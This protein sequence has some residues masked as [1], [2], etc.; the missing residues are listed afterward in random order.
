MR[1]AAVVLALA[2]VAGLLWFLDA[3]SAPV[4]VAVPAPTPTGTSDAPASV[5]PRT[6]ASD[7][8][9]AQR[10]PVPAGAGPERAPDTDALPGLRVRVRNAAGRPVEEVPVKADL[11]AGRVEVRPTGADGIATF[12]I[13]A[14]GDAV[15]AIPIALELPSLEA[16]R[17][18][19][20]A[21]SV[22]RGEVFDLTLPPCGVIAVRLLGGDGQPVGGTPIHLELRPLGPAETLADAPRRNGVGVTAQGGAAEFAF[23]PLH[24]AFALIPRANGLHASFA[25]ARVLGPTVDGQRVETTLREDATAACVVVRLVDAVRA[26]LRDAPITIDLSETIQVGESAG[27]SSTGTTDTTDADGELRLWFAA[28]GPDG[29]VRRVTFAQRTRP[30]AIGTLKLEH[31]LPAGITHV[32]DV[33]LEVERTV[34]LAGVVVDEAD[35]PVA[36]ARIDVSRINRFAGGGQARTGVALDARSDDAGAFAIHLAAAADAE[37]AVSARKDG[38]L[39]DGGVETSYGA[40]GLRLRLRHAGSITGSLAVEPADRELIGIRAGDADSR[41]PRD[42]RLDGETGAFAVASLAAGTYVV[43]FTLRGVGRPWLRVPDVIVRAGEATADPRLQAVALPAALHRVRVL[44]EDSAGRALADAVVR[45]DEP[46]DQADRIRLREHGGDG[47]TLLARPGTTWIAGAPGFRS[48][49]FTVTGDEQTVRLLPGI[50]LRV[51]IVGDYAAGHPD[52]RLGVSATP[53]G[54]APVAYFLAGANRSTSGQ[55]RSLDALFVHADEFPAG[56]DGGVLTLPTPGRWTIGLQAIAT[57]SGMRI[58]TPIRGESTQEVTIGEAGDEV[59]L[60]LTE[61]ALRAS[62]AR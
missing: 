1:A 57:A 2:V 53:T 33:V 17:A 35:A 24:S 8:T 50:P 5:S 9:A 15:T 21:A 59:T 4:G 18:D 3:G 19:V 20:P 12:P 38:Y 23:V 37:F 58:A 36:G 42:A 43:E 54:A 32:G 52:L 34:A 39:A 11:G 61:A 26:P 51:R 44:V 13:A 28:G 45:A 16:L 27:T 10:D 49:A 22:A 6:G 31:A 48:Q 25:P 14:R 30:E 29:R 56:A 7:A 60:R 46:D 62:Q 55:T 41:R 40:S 47:V